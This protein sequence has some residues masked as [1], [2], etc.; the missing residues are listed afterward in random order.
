MEVNEIFAALLLCVTFIENSYQIFSLSTLKSYNTK[1]NK[2]RLQGLFDL[3]I[4]NSQYPNKYLH[5]NDWTLTYLLLIVMSGGISIADH[6]I[7]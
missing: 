7:F 5:K 2:N 6:N 3:S 4:K 1:F